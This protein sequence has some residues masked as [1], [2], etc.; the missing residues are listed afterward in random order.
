MRRRTKGLIFLGVI[1]LLL[2][3]GTLVVL[4]TQGE[5]IALTLGDLLTSRVGRERNLSIEIGSIS[6]SLVSDVR[7]NDVIVTYTGDET[8]KTVFSAAEVRANFNLARILLGPARI[9]SLVLIS[10]RIALPTRA[11]GSRIYPMG[12]A[13]PGPP[14]K[15]SQF[16]FS[17]I[18]LT[19]AS[20]LWGGEPP[21]LV[22]GLNL[23]ASYVSEEER[24]RIEIDDAEFYYAKAGRIE[25][26]KGVF[27]ILDDRIRIGHLTV[28]TP[29]SRLG[30]SG[31]FGRGGVDSLALAVAIDSLALGEIPA[32]YGGEGKPEL[33]WLGGH[34]VIRGKYDAVNLDVALDGEVYGRTIRDLHSAISYASNKVEVERLSTLFEDIPLDLS[35][36]YTFSDPP[37]Y[38]G[39]VAFAGLDLSRFIDD[40]EGNFSSDLNG[41]VRFSGR[42]V[43][44]ERFS[45]STVPRL[46]A[47]RW[48]DWRFDSVVGKVDI[49]SKHVSLD[50]VFGMIGGTEVTS[51][52][53]IG[54]DGGIGL[55]FIFECPTLGGLYSYHKVEGLDGAVQGTARLK[56]LDGDLT[57]GVNSNCNDIDYKGT[58]IESLAVDLEI[59]QAGEDLRGHGEVFGSNLNIVGLKAS[60]F[61]GN[62]QIQDRRLNLERMVLTQ[63]DGSLLGVVGSVDLLDDGI[64]V[65]ID[66]LFVEL[67]GF[68]WENT[69]KIEASYKGDSLRVGHFEIG[70]ELGRITI[71][72]GS[73]SKGSYAFVTRVDDLDLTLLGD[74]VRKEIPTGTANLALAASGSQDSITFDLDFEITEGD[75]R[76]V[77][78]ESLTGRLS[79]DGGVLLLERIGLAQN[80][81]NVSIKGR[82]P[83]DLAPSRISN[84]A[85][86]GKG[87][88]IIDDLGHVSISVEDID[89]TLLEPLIPPVTKFRG[90][91]ELDIEI[92]GNKQ[93]PRVTSAGR[94]HGA[95]FDRTELGEV[96]WNFVL[97]DSVL[98]FADLA[99]GAGDEK[100]QVSGALPLA[101]SIL[102]FT[103]TLLDKP[104]GVHVL[105]E[106][107]DL[108]LMCDVF[109]RLKVCSGS[110]GVDLRIG[111]TVKDPTFDGHV[112]LSDAHLRVE[113][114]AQDILDL[115]L[116]LLAEGKRFKIA[117]MV[118]EDG[119]LKARGSFVLEGIKIAGWDLVIE[120]KDY[121]VT[122]F[123]DFYARLDGALT[124]SAEEIEPG[125]SVPKIEG[126]LTVKEG[127]Y[128]LALGATT[129]DE[130]LVSGTATPSWLLDVTVDIPK[131]FWIKGDIVHAELQGDLGV[132]RGREG[133]LVL[134]SLRTLRGNF[135]V[136][137]NSLR[138]TR[139]EFRFTD[140]KSFRNAYIDLE[141]SAMVLDE[142]IDLTATG[143]VDKLDVTATSESGWSE[144]Q[145]FEALLL[146]TVMGNC[147]GQPLW[148]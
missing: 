100:G 18:I 136:Y 41:S 70:S 127:E 126:E 46:Q 22:K 34:I 32:F 124:V 128:F 61:I 69:G 14:G 16:M 62:V 123:E 138:I 141:A 54:F 25:D 65:A 108:G 78:F 104:I 27:D 129:G 59:V 134:G 103:S 101:I 109:P 140:V 4:R 6:G 90:I 139:G 89:I 74:A 119:A 114:V 50:S 107:G 117:R 40:Q 99:F 131:A 64:D 93:N 77:E 45:L 142:R 66:N 148:R 72:E 137:H 88:D 130:G 120:L 44:A 98:S 36:E 110:Y 111:G 47:G 85:K 102:P 31:Y 51:V 39:V 26:L 146:P 29:A 95:V 135:N 86:T 96:S 23:K 13:K 53:R 76:A 118:A 106:G 63:K 30:L 38:S 121:E 80:G 125:L 1:I 7:L 49:T 3:I 112:T 143:Y 145:I 9:D 81:G 73:Y 55:E 87:F 67:A 12:D 79:Y 71:A 28:A 42:A 37:T 2:V 83:V 94:L 10:P 92:S 48:A 19:G 24:T 97:E 43:D 115:D 144:Q 20:V 132:R 133:L 11:D 60:E 58:H 122:E 5:R 91:A 17:N 75:I 82:I 8:P 35:C 57:F 84:L 105:V 15:R 147:T 113:G 116:E 33:G 56:R 21:R 68:I 52:G